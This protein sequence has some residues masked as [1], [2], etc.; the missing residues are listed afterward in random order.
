MSVN[1][2]I[3][4]TVFGGAA[5]R[6]VSAYTGKLLNDTDLYL[7]LPARIH[8]PRRRVKVT[9]HNDRSK[10][11]VA[12]IEDVGPW[13]INDAYWRKGERPQAETGFDLRGRKTNNAGIDLS[14]ALAEALGIDGMGYVD[15]EFA[16]DILS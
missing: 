11:A 13:N 2:K 4:A 6:N 15:W 8:G 14:P 12:S 7:S 3:L 5:D 9:N 1:L 10:S 16:P